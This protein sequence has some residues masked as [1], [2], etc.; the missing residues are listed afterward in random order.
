MRSRAEDDLVR[1]D[2]AL[3]GL[4]TLLDPDAFAEALGAEAPGADV[5]GAELTYLRYKPT[6]NC[7]A[8][9]RLQL[10]ETRLLVY[11]KAYGSDAAAKLHKLE[12]R[13]SV[14]GPLGAGRIVLPGPR[15]SVC[16]FPNDNKLPILARLQSDTRR[17]RLLAQL[18]P[19]RSE[20]WDA[21]IETLSYK[22]ER[23]YVGRL[24][25]PSG[26]DAVL[27][28]YEDRGYRAGASKSKRWRSGAMLRIA[29]RF[30]ASD[31]HR[32]VPLEWVE[33]D[34]LQSTLRAPHA[35]PEAVAD[36]GAALAEL[37]AQSIDKI[38]VRKQ[39]DE[40]GALSSIA[41]ALG[42]LLPTLAGRAVRIAWRLSSQLARLPDVRR[43]VHGDFYDRQVVLAAD[44]IAL[45]DL[46]RASVSLRPAIP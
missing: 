6:L 41:M 44:G 25:S 22:P 16:A 36:A 21:R 28:V 18:L 42:F 12:E 35:R 26:S 4:A 10:P 32:I 11:A 30:P 39:S 14:P 29:E 33:G 15:I 27:R 46:D 1:R 20:F 8:A 31:R 24:R 3:R 13:K 9:Y 38:E 43:P 45:L 37:H 17:R 7:L 23:R 40:V 5:R 19:Q 34:L 2:G